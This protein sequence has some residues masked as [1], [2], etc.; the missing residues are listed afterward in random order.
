M[1]AG[2]PFPEKGQ[3]SRMQINSRGI[4]D[5]AFWTT[6]AAVSSVQLVWNRKFRRQISSGLLL[7]SSPS[8]WTQVSKFGWIPSRFSSCSSKLNF[9]SVPVLAV[10]S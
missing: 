4:A 10:E 6:D 5:T 2:V 8:H 3:T 9:I 1:Q 7:P